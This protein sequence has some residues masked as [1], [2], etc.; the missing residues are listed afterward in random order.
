MQIKK[1]RHVRIWPKSR[2]TKGYY[3]SKQGVDHSISMHQVTGHTQQVQQ[4]FGYPILPRL[5]FCSHQDT[6]QNN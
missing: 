2:K 1:I 3:I 6:A 4:D 5:T